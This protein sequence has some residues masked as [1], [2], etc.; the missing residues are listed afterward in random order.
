MGEVVMADYREDIED[1]CSEIIKA[2]SDNAWVVIEEKLSASDLFKYCYEEFYNDLSTIC[3]NILNGQSVDRAISSYLSTGYNRDKFVQVVRDVI[4]RIDFEDDFDLAEE[5][6]SALI[7][8][9]DLWSVI[10]FYL[11]PDDI[12][13]GNGFDVYMSFVNDVEDIML[14]YYSTEDKNESLTESTSRKEREKAYNDLKKFIVKFCNVEWSDEYM[15]LVIYAVLNSNANVK[16]NY[17][18]IEDTC[19]NMLGNYP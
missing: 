17:M 14:E 5:I 6:D 12:I 16:S 8:D 7:Y 18:N 13:N 2:N 1:A 10:E 15:D 19:S 9:E 3:S 11:D 4:S